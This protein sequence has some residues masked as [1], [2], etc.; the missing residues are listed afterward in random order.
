M[1]GHGRKGNWDET[2]TSRFPGPR[3]HARRL[4]LNG[5][6]A[7]TN[8]HAG[9]RTDIR[10]SQV[11]FKRVFHLH[12]AINAERNKELVRIMCFSGQV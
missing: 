2:K 12:Y 5:S 10:R 7:G 4:I 1:T 9:G 3:S 6:T 8:E 11:F